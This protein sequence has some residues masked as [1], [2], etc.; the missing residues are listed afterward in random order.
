ML[1][2]VDLAMS[3][4]PPFEFSFHSIF[5]ATL[6]KYCFTLTNE[7][8]CRSFIFQKKFFFFGTEPVESKA[9][10]SYLRGEKLQEVANKNVAWSSSTGQG[11]LYFSKKATEKASPAGIFNLV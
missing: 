1:E 2:A 6:L 4:E 10:Q 7:N 8:F 3:G 11:L 5:F 9:L